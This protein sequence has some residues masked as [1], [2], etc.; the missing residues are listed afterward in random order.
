[1][2]YHIRTYPAERSC[3]RPGHGALSELIGS[4]GGKEKGVQ[5][6]IWEL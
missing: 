2:S 5:R 3:G 4:L 6:L 1:M